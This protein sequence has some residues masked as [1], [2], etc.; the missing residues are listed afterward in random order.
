MAKRRPSK[1]ELRVRFSHPAPSIVIAL[2]SRAQGPS[3]PG[4][5]GNIR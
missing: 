3:D 4:I 1:S 5:G 2:C